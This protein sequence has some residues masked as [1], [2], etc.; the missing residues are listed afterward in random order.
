MKQRTILTSLAFT[1]LIFVLSGFQC[2]STEMTTAKLNMQRNEWDAAERNLAKETAKNP[3]NSEAWFYLGKS[4]AFL[5]KWEGMVEA[6][7]QSMK[8][9]NEFTGQ[10]KDIKL[11][12]WARNFNDAIVWHN[13]VTSV[14]K[15]SAGIYIQKALDKYKIALVINPDSAA[16][17]QNLAALYSTIP[18]Y[19]NEILNLKKA[20][21]RKPS[22]ELSTHLINS[23]VTKGQAAKAKGDTQTSNECYDL[24]IAELTR[25]RQSDPSNE[26]LLTA[27]INLYIE[28]GRTKEATPLIREALAKDPSNKVLQNNL[29]LLLM[30]EGKIDE[31]VEHFDAALKTDESY[32]QALRNGAVAYMKIGATMK[33]K[34]EAAANSQKDNVDKSYQ[35]KFKKAVDMLNRLL[36]TEKAATDPNIWDALAT[37]YGNASMYKEAKEAIQKADSLRKK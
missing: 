32:D 22:S 29:G 7:D 30:D 19:D 17:Y 25:A 8:T 12:T 9:G 26:D 24:A 37:A 4:R 5:E 33:E 16:T 15:D 13:K 20:L 10:I 14:S 28:R 23:Y 31:A 1:F 2:G 18:D 6:F 11:A 34:A 36:K 35:E 27:M 3:T 21:E